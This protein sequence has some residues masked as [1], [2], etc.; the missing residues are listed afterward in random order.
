MRQLVKKTMN[1]Q[2]V[3][4]YVLLIAL[5]FLGV[6][7]DAPVIPRPVK[8]PCYVGATFLDEQ[9]KPAFYLNET[10]WMS[11]SRFLLGVGVDIPPNTCPP[12]P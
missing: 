3:P 4:A 1:R 7:V 9:K 8:V 2:K 10:E 6:F 12:I 5:V 11:P